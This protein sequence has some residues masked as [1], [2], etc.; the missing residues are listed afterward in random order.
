M[1][2]FLLVLAVVL[3]V[4]A[5]AAAALVAP[6][7]IASPSTETPLAVGI[8]ANGRG[9][10]VLESGGGVFGPPTQIVVTVP[11]AKRTS[12]ADT[13]LLD[14]A[15]RPDGGLDMLVRRGAPGATSGDLILRRVLASG[16]MLDLWS[17]RSAATTGALVRGANRTIVVWPQGST[18]RIMTRPDGG[19]PSR[20]HTA[21]LAL[22][23]ATDL[24]VAIDH[25]DRLVVA[26]SAPLSGLVLAS[27]TSRGTVAH[28]QAAP[29]ARG[30]VEIAVTAG[31]RVGVLVEDTAQDAGDSE[32]ASAGDGRRIRAVLRE[33]GAARFGPVQSIESPPFECVQ[34]PAL[35]RATADDGLTVLYQGG[36][37][38][39][40]PLLVRTA[41]A[42]RGKRFAAPTTL[43]SDARAAAAVVTPAGGLVIAL[44]RKTTQQEVFFGALSLVRSSTAEES[45]TPGPTSSPV[46]ALDPA[47]H[48]VLAWRTAD[49][50]QI[51]IDA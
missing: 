37:Y 49:A 12:F 18:L 30:R 51:A 42:A 7:S 8:G 26:V 24:D 13:T 22:K 33:R 28:R 10:V 32:C 21:R 4:P 25:G 50:L 16:R 23:G 29:G 20:P 11:G 36:S 48:P 46:L 45:V 19:I 47:G 5:T 38:D 17:V 41:T 44:V 3:C 14:S 15:R 6:V 2:A 9:F 34:T 27:L 39:T 1:R 35:L 40:P 43:A 31:G